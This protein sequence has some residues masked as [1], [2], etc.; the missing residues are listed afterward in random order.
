MKKILLNY[1]VMLIF[2]LWLGA[3]SHDDDGF[4]DDLTGQSLKNM[5]SSETSEKY[6]FGTPMEEIIG[7]WKLTRQGTLDMS[8]SGTFL[9]FD[10]KNNNVIY[11]FQMELGE[12]CHAHYESTYSFEDDWKQNEEDNTLSGHVSFL[13]GGNIESPEEKDRLF[14][15]F[16]GEHMI[17]IPDMGY[18]YYLD[19]TMY[20]VRIK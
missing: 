5:V 6:Q 13:M 20:F 8:N 14:C 12:E 15:I 4:I 10:K 3:C 19:P 16:T 2:S 1:L 7:K 18:N 9:K 11:D 17:L